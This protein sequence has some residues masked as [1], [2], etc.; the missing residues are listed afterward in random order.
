[1]TQSSKAF[2][3]L[4]N[5]SRAGLVNF[6]F[7]IGF[8]LVVYLWGKQLSLPDMHVWRAVILIAIVVI[9]GILW[10][11]FFYIRDRREPEPVTYTLLSFIAGMAAMALLVLPLHRVLFRIPEWIH[12]TTSLF[13][14]GSFLVYAP[15]ICVALYLIIRYGFYPVREFDEPVD[16]MVYG[17]FAGCGMAFVF[18]V[19]NGWIN[20]NHTIFVI[21]YTAT[22]HVLIY[23]GVG[24]LIGYMIGRA[25]F[26][27]RSVDF[28]G[29][30]SIFVAT[31]LLGAY[32]L[33][34]KFVFI[35]GIS[36]AFWL[37]FAITMIYVFIILFFCVNMMKRL[38]RGDLHQSIR[39]RNR[40]DIL[41]TAIMVLF[42]FAGGVLAQKGLN[43]KIFKDIKHGIAF[44]FPHALSRFPFQYYAQAAFSSPSNRVLFM[45][46]TMSQ[47]RY[48]FSVAFL[49]QA[50]ALNDLDLI[51]FISDPDPSTVI[52]DDVTRADK[53]GKRLAFAFMKTNNNSQHIFPRY[54]QVYK[55]FFRVNGNLYIFT[56]EA[57]AEHFKA[58][59]GQYEK[60]LQS[61]EWQQAGGFDVKD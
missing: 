27:D 40:V 48:T 54:I 11:L 55:D 16:G 34:D 14:F 1:M 4:E 24:A 39:I 31:L 15:I 33:F 44:R 43:G 41:T 30:L 13:V 57:A 49:Q 9:P 19:Y 12:E 38:T 25:K 58:G 51:S 10:T 35:K 26:S 56:Y 42:L 17:A 6:I 50:D 2:K 61:V 8:L 28:Y 59:L 29:G 60:I 32:Y 52:L 22:T 18:S 47:P 37:S 23:S 45:A 5:I 36:H 46:Q 21:G 53:K 3:R 7:Q 20:P